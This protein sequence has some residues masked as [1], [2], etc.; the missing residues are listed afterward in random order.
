MMIIMRISTRRAEGKLR[1]RTR[2]LEAAARRLRTHGLDGAAIVPVMEEAGL[3]HGTFYSHFDSKEELAN[4]AFT[5]SLTVGRP[6]W[7]TP[8]SGESWVARLKGLADWYL[9]AEHRDDVP[10][11]CG[12]AALGSEAARGSAEFRATFE[13]ELR[14]SLAAIC[15][16][17]NIAAPAGSGVEPPDSDQFDDAVALMAICVGGLTLSRAVTDSQLSS[18]IL[19][20]ALRAAERITDDTD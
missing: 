13:R 15:G 3:T 6:R 9:S 1:S 7:I 2:I 18:R 17:T 12:F 10:N 4:A 19:T 20:V 11:G 16:D 5:H 8:M 14:I